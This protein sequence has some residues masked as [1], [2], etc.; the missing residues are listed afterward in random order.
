MSNP[1]RAFV[2]GVAAATAAGRS[3]PLGGPAVEP[4]PARP[5]APKALIFSPHPDDECIIG[6]LALRLRRELG[7]E[8]VNVAVTLGSLEARRAERW[9][10]L[11]AAC[12]LLGF[13]LVAP[14]DGGFSGIRPEAA[15]ERPGDWEAAVEATAAVIADERPQVVFLPHD[16]DWN[17]THLGTH[18][19]VTEA[20][21][22]QRP[23]FSC[24]A[25]ETEFWGAMDDPNL[26]V[27]IADTDLGDLVAALARHVGEVRRNPYHLRLP[28]WM[29]DN[30][31]R[32]GELVLGQ[33]AAPPDFTF[34]TLYRL[35][36]WTGGGFRQRLDG[37]CAVAAADSLETLFSGRPPWK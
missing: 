12:G 22:R 28:A 26:M 30:V 25:V 4:P 13:R 15:S 5:G 19:L 17:R 6:G 18:M 3:L 29:I 32:G 27:E 36:D 35:R 34:A 8:I 37:G 24:T 23:V 31:R 21:A 7:F 20:L 10:E 2:A 9:R 11:E 1:Y 16:R 14:R 33:G